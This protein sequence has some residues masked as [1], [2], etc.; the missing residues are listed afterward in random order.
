MDLICKTGHCKKKL[1]EY[2]DLTRK[3]YDD[4]DNLETDFK[5]KEDFLQKIV[6]ARNNLQEDVFQLRKKNSDLVKENNKLS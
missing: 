4:I 6:K 5:D 1:N 2:R 3:L